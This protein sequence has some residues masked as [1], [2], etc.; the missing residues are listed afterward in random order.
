M[1]GGSN[2]HGC[3]GFTVELDLRVSELNINRTFGISQAGN[4][5]S[6]FRLAFQGGGIRAVEDLDKSVSMKKGRHGINGYQAIEGFFIFER[7]GGSQ[8][9]ESSLDLF[10]RRRKESRPPPDAESNEDDEKEN[11][12]WRG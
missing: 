10:L 9:L 12:L 5:F 11:S 6:N 2:K 8:F 3:A 1:D 7:S 4:R